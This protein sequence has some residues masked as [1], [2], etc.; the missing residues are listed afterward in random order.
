MKKIKVL[1]IEDNALFDLQN[2]LGPIFMDGR[3]DLAIAETASD[4]IQRLMQEEFGAVIVDIRLP[5]GDDPDWVRLYK[6]PYGLAARLGLALLYSLFCQEEAEIKHQRIPPWVSP[7]RF[8]VF[9]VESKAEVQ[10]H[11]DKL[12]VSVYEQKTAQ[13]STRVIL[14]ILERIIHKSK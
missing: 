8:G 14:N 2:V 4:G 9:T 5:P 12:K 13:T 6:R 11:L 10:P 1:W 3:Y 7:D